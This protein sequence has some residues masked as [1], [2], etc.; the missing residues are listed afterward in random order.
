[1]ALEIRPTVGSSSGKSPPAPA[2][3]AGSDLFSIGLAP[4]KPAAVPARAPRDDQRAGSTKADATAGEQPDSAAR[5]DTPKEATPAS[6][7]STDAGDDQSGDDGSAASNSRARTNN[8]T[9]PAAARSNP[10][11][12]RQSAE[13]QARDVAEQAAEPAGASLLQ[14]LA[15]SLDTQTDATPASETGDKAPPEFL[16]STDAS[17]DPNEQALSIFT[18]ALA[19]AL[20]ASSAL[21]PAANTPA[22]NTPAA[23]VLSGAGE[24][25]VGEVTRSTRGM[26]GS[27]LL[28]I[29]G[30][31]LAA[32]PK[33]A[34]TPVALQSS[35]SATNESTRAQPDTNPGS[36]TVLPHLGLASHFAAPA[37]QSVAGTSELKSTVGSSAW[38]EEIGT[39]LTWMTQ[40]GLETGSL[41][42]SPEHLGP[43][44]VQISVQNGGAS[45]WFGANH[46]DTRAALE[47]ALPRLRE[48]FASQGMTLT[49]SGVSRES[50]RNQSRTSTAS[51]SAVA[52]QVGS[53]PVTVR[54]SL[55]LVDTYA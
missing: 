5:P 21:P 41:R 22:A 49:D 11:A 28:S 31:D 55:G 19:A 13:Q 12:Q 35:P 29:L 14:I 7:K 18:Q 48:M 24:Q 16:K 33:A 42:V 6:R 8:P 43:V 45:V 15:Q 50:P 30:K 40:K 25:A 51:I 44:E 38:T 23:P 27:E 39:H 34:A 47:Q 54:I 2:K 17:A 10:A 4:Q 9:G 20:G 37:A 1:M 36:A 46:A 32:D 53:E 3:H 26:Q 52:T